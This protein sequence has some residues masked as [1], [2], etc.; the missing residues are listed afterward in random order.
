MNIYIIL[1]MTVF[2]LAYSFYFIKKKKRDNIFNFAGLLIM[3]LIQSSGD[4]WY[5][6]AFAII[7]GIDLIILL[8]LTEGKK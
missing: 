2:Y 1:A 4:N 7:I 3:S 5:N 8:Y 6:Y